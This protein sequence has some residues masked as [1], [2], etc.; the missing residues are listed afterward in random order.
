[1]RIII[2]MTGKSS[3]FKEAGVSLPKQ[4]LKVKNKM[5]IDYILEL[6]P[7]E[8]DI[9]L[10]V[11]KEQ[12]GDEV[13]APYFEKLNNHNIVP[14]SYQDKGPGGA[15]LSSN[16]LKTD[17]QVFINY[18]DFANIWNWED[19]KQLIH[20][21]KP[22]GIHCRTPIFLGSKRDVDIIEKLFSPIPR[23]AGILCSAHLIAM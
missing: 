18:C 15:L 19:F 11:N 2:P 13:L 1:M 23:I 7:D 3:R 21:K 22:D 20:D 17:K 14:I 8:K 12:L 16:L 5:I 4:F 9:N 6:F 10:L